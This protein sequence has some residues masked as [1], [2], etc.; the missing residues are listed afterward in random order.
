M[1]Q[2]IRIPTSSPRAMVGDSGG[3]DTLFNKIVAKG[4]GLLTYNEPPPRHVGAVVIPRVIYTNYSGVSWDIGRF[5]WDIRRLN[6]SLLK[7]STG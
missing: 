7:R 5:S 1:H 4:V 2:S 6:F 3:M